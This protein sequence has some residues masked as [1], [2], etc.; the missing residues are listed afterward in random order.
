PQREPGAP[1]TVASVDADGVAAKSGLQVGDE[2]LR[3]NN[4][5]VPRRPERWALQQKPGDVLRLRI[6]RAEKEESIEIH[7]GEV[8]ARF[9]QVTEMPHADDRARHLRDGILHGTT[10]PVT[11]RTH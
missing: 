7:L 6:R 9:F 8:R 3:W 1:W 2:I 5:E 4:A 11:A 10:D